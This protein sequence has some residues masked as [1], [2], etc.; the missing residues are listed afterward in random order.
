MHYGYFV[1]YPTG[2][3]LHRGGILLLVFLLIWELVWKGMALWRAGRNH[4]SG[5]FIAILI[6]NTAGILPIIYLVFFQ[7]KTNS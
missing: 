1:N 7:P 6:L 4:H 2:F 5:W 3:S